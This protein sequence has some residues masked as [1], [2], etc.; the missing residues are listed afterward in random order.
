M[1]ASSTIFCVFV[2]TRPGIEP[3]SPEPL[4]KTL[5]I[6]PMASFI[7]K[8]KELYINIHKTRKTILYIKY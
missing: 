7:S 3:R 5:L 4:A 6:R 1:T 8:F 2:M